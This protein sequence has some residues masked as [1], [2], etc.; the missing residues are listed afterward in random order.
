MCQNKQL[1]PQ[2]PSLNPIT[3]L[4]EG[5]E[6]NPAAIHEPPMQASFTTLILTVF[7]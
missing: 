4:T 2:M 7:G 3:A 5:N 6:A 1:L